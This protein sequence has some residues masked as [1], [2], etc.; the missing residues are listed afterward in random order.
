VIAPSHVDTLNPTPLRQALHTLMAEVAVKDELIERQE[1]ESAFK[2]AIIDKLTHEMAVLKRLFAIGVTD[3]ALSS[4]F[5]TG[6]IRGTETA[7]R[8]RASR[9]LPT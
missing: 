2:Q 9:R 5:E 8:F 4:E 6:S 1:R 7:V 3:A